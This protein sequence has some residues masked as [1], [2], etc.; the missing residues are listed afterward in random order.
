MARETKL[1]KL[2]R[3]YRTSKNMSQKQLASE[4]RAK[5]SLIRDIENFRTIDPQ[6]RE[7]LEFVFDYSEINF[8]NKD[9]DELFIDEEVEKPTPVAIATKV[10]KK[11]ETSNKP[12]AEEKKVVGKEPTP[13]IN[14][15]AGRVRNEELDKAV[16]IKEL[17]MLRL[18]EKIIDS[19]LDCFGSSDDDG[20]NRGILTSIQ[21]IKTGF[22][23]EEVDA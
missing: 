9:M 4:V 11:D 3:E 22:K 20:Y 12:D 17:E 10:D 18:K 13:A 1:G 21:V 5:T 7:K 19:L 15:P 16:L 23:K 2:L 8:T 14:K 6:N